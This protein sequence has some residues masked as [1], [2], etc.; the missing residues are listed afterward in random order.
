M[1]EALIA[2]TRATVGR[3]T[4]ET[5]GE[6]TGTSRTEL[7]SFTHVTRPTSVSPSY[8]LL[9]WLVIGLAEKRL[10][11]PPFQRLNSGEEVVNLRMS[12][13]GGARW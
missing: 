12:E 3:V 4:W 11:E 10:D 8:H 2:V 1:K 13:E 6:R 7:Y 5:T 9:R